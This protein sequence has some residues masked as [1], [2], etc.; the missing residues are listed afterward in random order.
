MCKFYASTGGCDA[1]IYGAQLVEGTEALPY[2]KTETRLNRPRV[3]FSLPGCPNLLLEPQ[4]TNFYIT[5]LVTTTIAINPLPTSTIVS[6]NGDGT[7]G[8]FLWGAQLEAG[9]YATSY[10]PTTTASVTSNADSITRNNI[11]TNGLIT[12]AGGTW[13]VEFRNNVD[14]IRDGSGI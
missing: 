11:Y 3:D 14:Y 1:T 6:Y 7:S 5:N 12:A 10:I 4:R 2:L 9:S 13:F 8:I